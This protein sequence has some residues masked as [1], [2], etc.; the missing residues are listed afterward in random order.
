MSDPHVTAAV[1]ALAAEFMDRTRRGERPTVEEYA[2]LHPELAAQIR[3]LFPTI[4]ALEDLRAQKV[5]S[6]STRATLGGSRL[7]QLGDFRIVRELGRG[8]MGVVYEAIQESLNRR[9][10][11]KVLARHARL[12]DSYRQR[13]I[14]EAK[15][16]A[17]LHH[18]NIVPILGVGEHDGFDFY[19]M[20]YIDGIG[21]D[22]IITQMRDAGRSS[23]GSQRL[24][25][26]WRPNTELLPLS[27]LH[28]RDRRSGDTPGRSSAL[29]PG[30]QDPPSSSAA[31]SR[32]T[33]DATFRPAHSFWQDVA[34]IG[35]Q[36]AEALD[37]AHSQGTLHRDIKPGNLLLD[38][39]GTLWVADFGLAKAE[40]QDA[41]S[42]TGD[43]LG[44]LYYMA[45]EQWRGQAD[46]RSDVFSLGVSLYEMLALRLPWDRRE[47]ARVLAGSSGSHA[48]V[49][50][51]QYAV[52]VP[53]DL[54]TIVM[55]AIA[56]EPTQRYATAGELAADL[57][58]FLD[59]LPIAARPPRLFER[60][61]RWCRKNPAVARL[62][63]LAVGLLAVIAVTSALSNAANRAAFQRELALR[64]KT[65]DTL[66]I[67]L[68]ALERVYARLAPDRFGEARPLAVSADETG[69]VAT[70]QPNISPETAALLEELLPLYDRLAD[71]SSSH[72]RFQVEAARASRRIGDI[73]LRL[74]N[75]AQ[76]ETAYRDALEQYEALAA[77]DKASTLDVAR[78]HNQLGTVL[79]HTRS[80]EQAQAEHRRALKLL[81]A[82]VDTATPE[83]KFEM[84]LSYYHLG[85]A[86]EPELIV[87]T[88]PDE[89]P[90][91][92]PLRRGPPPLGPD[93]PPDDPERRGP[94]G[95]RDDRRPEREGSGPRR[96]EDK[97]TQ[98]PENR[99][100]PEEPAARTT[101]N[102]G[103]ELPVGD[104]I[105]LQQAVAFLKPLV[106]EFPDHPEYRRLLAVC[107]RELAA[108]ATLPE[109]AEPIGL[110][111]QL[112]E[113]YPNVPDYRYELAATYSLLDA[114][115]LKPSETAE[116]EKR[117]RAALEQS[118]LLVE[119]QPFAP[120]YAS[121]HVHI[122]NKLTR[123]MRES[124]PT[125]AWSPPERMA[126]ID[127]IAT[128]SKQALH[129][130]QLLMEKHPTVAAY[131]FWFAKLSRSVAE[132]HY[133]RGQQADG[134]KLLTQA[135]AKLNALPESERASPAIKSQL[136]ELQKL[137]K[138]PPPAM[139]EGG[140]EPPP[141][142]R[143]PPFGGPG[144]LGPGGFGPGGPGTGGPGLF[145]PPNGPPP[146]GPGGTAN[147]GTP[148]SN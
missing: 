25:T 53:R 48:P 7:T 55:K 46:R 50:L 130:Q 103:P 35:W 99:L 61:W 1:D 105:Q 141:W 110:L 38:A 64:Q 65:E 143:R 28:E 138:D 93:G 133:L 54:E 59:D 32:P 78:L 43:V 11:V 9:V 12:D 81:A 129:R 26:F 95:K 90:R 84:A 36:A 4:A 56:E 122:L 66:G 80:R 57:R 131:S 113:Q 52:G 69:G 92:D 98:P 137:E 47:R 21:L 51:R 22:R 89:L 139:F 134:A 76:A 112:V 23:I 18:T 82:S 49:P 106:S 111:Q 40:E 97:G 101:T 124:L 136:T 88:G 72:D 109:L 125:S 114:R 27:G 30:P 8:G 2:A 85:R 123:V 86:P 71:Q 77:E 17:R 148:R 117:L 5:R 19:V 39:Q 74:G 120:D 132:M 75:F 10:A 115:R 70:A 142:E 147:P 3:E 67:S 73:R 58:R 126:R 107:A 144:G 20:Q 121:Q 96:P 42:R 37:Y 94:P 60:A 62:S 135:V 31:V 13:F 15:T 104:T 6:N 140:R 118:T 33:S 63:A 91:L 68:E 116:A 79:A 14:R 100:R 102:T 128:L 29:T 146:D 145:G 119:S 24:S 41:I 44:T 127:E 83:D 87:F 108:P 34:E 16:A 45:P